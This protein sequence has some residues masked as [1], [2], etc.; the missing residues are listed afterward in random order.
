MRAEMYLTW[1]EFVESVEAQM[2]AKG[3]DPQHDAVPIDYIDFAYAPQVRISLNR[4][5]K[6]IIIVEGAPNL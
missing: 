6:S 5:L 3:I 1:R 2:R 4:T